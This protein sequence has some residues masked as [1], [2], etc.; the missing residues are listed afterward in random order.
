MTRPIKHIITSSLLS[1][2]LLGAVATTASAAATQSEY[3]LQGGLS[4]FVLL[5][6]MYSSG[7]M[8]LN[9]ASEN[10]NKWIN[11]VNNSGDK[12]SYG[13]PLIMGALSYTLVDTGTIFTLGGE[14]L[15]GG[16]SQSTDHWGNINIGIYFE[17]E[18]VWKDP[19]LTNS[20]RSRTNRDSLLYSL[21]W[22]DIMN[23]PL[24]FHYQL[25]DIDIDDDLAG[26]RN[27]RLQRNG[28]VHQLSLGSGLFMNDHQALAVELLYDQANLSGESMSY[29]GGGAALFYILN[30]INWELESRCSY[31]HLKYDGRHPEFDKTRK[32][33]VYGIESELTFFQPFGL[34]NYFITVMISY[35][36]IDANID[37]Y[38]AAPVTT[39]LAIGFNF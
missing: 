39:G 19:F 31:Q 1:F 21:E 26:Q 35:E 27:K 18:K 8:S 25:E 28:Q 38:D 36:N 24:F 4:G 20:K 34:E 3:P 12:H 33:H 22:S 17:S 14:G 9:D 30:G 7:K 13:S 6:G 2:F 5:G 10:Q 29:Q 11:S 16:I 32:D 37:F 15:G 23:T